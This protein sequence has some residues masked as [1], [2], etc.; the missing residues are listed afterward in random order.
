[1]LKHRGDRGIVDST[2]EITEGGGVEKIHDEIEKVKQEFFV[3]SLDIFS[4]LCVC[5]FSPPFDF[6]F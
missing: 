2:R 5:D 4:G 1:M 6:G 3:S